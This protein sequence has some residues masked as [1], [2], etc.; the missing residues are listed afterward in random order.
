MSNLKPGESPIVRLS[1]TDHPEAG[2]AVV[3]GLLHGLENAGSS[4]SAVP[5]F[6]EASSQRRKIGLK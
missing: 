2:F 4:N 6:G 1:K 3:S 5:G